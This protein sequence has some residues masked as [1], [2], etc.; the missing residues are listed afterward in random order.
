MQ[1][2]DFIA[3][4][5]TLQQATTSLETVSITLQQTTTSVAGLQSQLCA[6]N[7]SLRDIDSTLN[8]NTARS[9]SCPEL[10]VVVP[11]KDSLDSSASLQL[12][13]SQTQPLSVNQMVAELHR[14]LILGESPTGAVNSSFQNAAGRE[15]AQVVSSLVPV[16][17]L[18]RRI[19]S[20]RTQLATTASRLV[21]Y[22]EDLRSSLQNRHDINPVPH[23]VGGMLTSRAPS[24]RCPKAGSSPKQHQAGIGP[25]RYVFS[26]RER[27]LYGCP[28]YLEADC[29]KTHALELPI[30]PFL[31]GT[32]EL[33]STV[34]ARQRL[35]SFSIKYYPTTHRASSPAFALL[36]GAFGKFKDHVSVP[37]GRRGGVHTFRNTEPS[38]DLQLLMQGIPENLEALFSSGAA[39][40]SEKDEFGNTLLF[41]SEAKPTFEEV[42]ATYNLLGTPPA[43]SICIRN[44]GVVPRFHPPH[45]PHHSTA[46]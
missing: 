29:E 30:L 41:V 36:H 14:C 32:V 13:Q 5:G 2:G 15:K 27:H 1:R 3:I 6:V 21:Q 8:K 31:A 28:F 26:S 10:S 11:T 45:Q 24:C 17:G 12:G 42:P 20:L 22:P 35:T 39:L 38:K 43:V 37:S 16:V 40:P 44:F 33:F 18:C 34:C 25:F 9:S 46:H 7:S 19:L 4:S 23:S